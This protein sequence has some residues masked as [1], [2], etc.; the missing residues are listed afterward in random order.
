MNY[1]HLR[2]VGGIFVIGFVTF[3]LASCGPDD[4]CGPNQFPVLSTE[5]GSICVD[6]GKPIPSGYHE[7]PPGK[8]PTLAGR[9]PE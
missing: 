9:T 6:Q 1:S 2:R 8:T 5:G 7:Y 4:E 3:S